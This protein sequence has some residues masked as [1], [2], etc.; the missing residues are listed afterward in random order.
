MEEDHVEGVYGLRP[1][2]LRFHWLQLRHMT[3]VTCRRGVPGWQPL[4]SPNT[5]LGKGNHTFL[6]DGLLSLPQGGCLA[7]RVGMGTSLPHFIVT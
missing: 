4:L 2:S 3:T 1:T 7:D 5:E 6:R